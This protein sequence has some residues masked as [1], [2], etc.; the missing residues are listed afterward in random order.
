MT[1]ENIEDEVDEL[2]GDD[3]EDDYGYEIDFDDADVEQLYDAHPLVAHRMGSVDDPIEIL[4]DSDNDIEPP[5]PK[6]IA[7]TIQ[8]EPTV[9]SA[10][11]REDYK[12][13]DEDI[14]TA[15][16]PEFSKAARGNREH[17]NKKP[18]THSD[19]PLEVIDWVLD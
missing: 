5:T 10:A 18:Y 9:W 3:D 4:S 12:D 15:S 16:A 1:P 6:V 19:A 8:S 13:D 11:V 2:A 17:V 14:I 7:H